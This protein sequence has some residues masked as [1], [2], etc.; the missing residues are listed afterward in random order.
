MGRYLDSEKYGTKVIDLYDIVGY[1]D[2]LSE[3]SILVQKEDSN[4]SIRVEDLKQG[5]VIRV[6]F[7]RNRLP[8]DKK[9]IEKATFID[10]FID[11]SFIL[12]R[13]D[14]SNP[15]NLIHPNFYKDVLLDGSTPAE[16]RL[17]RE[18]NYNRNR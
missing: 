1:A 3:G 17:Y 4:Y 16:R 6:D 18:S 12:P 5:K 2:D 15:D 9:P 14:T 10:D 7:S 13:N 11:G 8:D